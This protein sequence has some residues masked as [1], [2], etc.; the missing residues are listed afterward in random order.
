[1]MVPEKILTRDEVRE[2]LAE[3]SESISSRLDAIESEMPLKVKTLKR[4]SKH[5][6]VIK[7]GAAVGA[8][9]IVLAYLLRRKST[10]DST[11]QE[12]LERIAVVIALEIS[13]NLKAGMRAEEAV[14]SA[15]RKRPP[16]LQLGT[17]KGRRNGSGVLSVIARQLAVSIGPA[18]VEIAVEMVRRSPEKEGK[19]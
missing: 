14:S 5:A 7:K 12:G 3:R 6:K 19:K 11:Y 16:V 10:S 15:L 2:K 8:C 17:Q 18:L 9:V 4:L 1:M 13:R